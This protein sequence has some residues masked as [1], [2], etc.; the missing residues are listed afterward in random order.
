MPQFEHPFQ[1]FT[2]DYPDSWEPMYQEETGGL[3]LVHPGDESNAGALS[4]TPIAVNGEL[5]PAKVALEINAKHIGSVL[6][7]G[8][9][10]ASARDG[11]QIAYGEG[12]G[13]AKIPGSRLRFWV[14]RREKVALNVV[15][16]GPAAT[17][18]AQRAHADFALE[19]LTF[20]EILPPTPA[21]FQAR[22]LDIL[23]REHPDLKA[24]ADGEW[25]IRIAKS[26]GEPY[27]ALG[28][29]NL[30]R[31]CLLNAESIGA[32][33][34]EHL[35]KLFAAT[36][37]LADF[38]NFGDARPHLMP[39]LK[40]DSWAENASGD[41]N[42]PH[43][44]FAP[45][46]SV[47]FVIDQPEQ[48][49]YVNAEHLRRW[50]VPLERVEEVSLDNLAE[51]SKGMQLALMQDENGNTAGV[52]LATNDGYDAARFTLPD[53]RERLAE[54][55]GDEYY[56]GV[57]NRDFLIAFTLR[58]RESAVTIARQIRADYQ[59]MNYPL[60]PETFLVRP[61]RIEVAQL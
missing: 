23:A 55:L 36:P 20:P 19:T 29:E 30:Y 45:G 56:V 34:R 5:P 27:T 17:D 12:S 31:S 39:M 51:R 58:D 52:V 42:L 16:L 59:R 11:I 18:S 1:L 41:K 25:G 13:T 9:I 26:E 38:P 61:E 37:T 24:E 54:V 10:R 44:A 4:L 53:V 21:E 50:D 43:I 6:D 7:R 57:P 22:V 40:P 14:V 48:V 33:I 2:L 60:S 46:L 47:C 35:E 32:L 28:L 49:V 3:I 8:T 15:Q